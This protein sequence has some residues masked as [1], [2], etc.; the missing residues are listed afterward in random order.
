MVE[1][2]LV[3]HEY[4]DCLISFTGNTESAYVVADHGE[5]IA[6]RY[7]Q[8]EMAFDGTGTFGPRG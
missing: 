8:Y 1:I 6:G 2:R 3:A 7:E 4:H 5:G